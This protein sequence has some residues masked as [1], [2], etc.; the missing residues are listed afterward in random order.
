VIRSARTARVIALLAAAV[1]LVACTGHPATEDRDSAG[2]GKVRATFVIDHHRFR[3]SEWVEMVS[4]TGPTDERCDLSD[5]GLS[6]DALEAGTLWPAGDWIVAA[7]TV[8]GWIEPLP[9]RITVRRGQVT[10]L[11]LRYRREQ[12]E[13]PAWE[14]GLFGH[15]EFPIG[16]GLVFENG[17]RQ[18]IDG[19]YVAVFAGARA[20]PETIEPSRVGVILVDVIEPKTWGH[21]FFFSVA[22]IPGP[23]RIVRVDGHRLTVVSP[24]GRTA[25]FD[26]DARRFV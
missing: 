3:G 21:T 6:V 4:P 18:V 23:V 14:A 17:W 19:R 7:P 20:K 1:A 12:P 26:V 25:V 22:P 9:L 15:P 11:T 2:D 10:E 13:Q 5:C 8:K 24:S 16:L